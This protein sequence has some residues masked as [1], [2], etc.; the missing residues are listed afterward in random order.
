MAVPG[1]MAS[2][3]DLKEKRIE[4][5]R[6]EDLYF[7]REFWYIAVSA[8]VW[9]VFWELAERNQNN[10]YTQT[11]AWAVLLIAVWVCYNF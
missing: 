2:S 8:L 5:V 3:H 11:L 10:P 6:P 4:E 7:E 9:G 1:S